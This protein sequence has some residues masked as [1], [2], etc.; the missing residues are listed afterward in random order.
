MVTVSTKNA[1]YNECLANV[2]VKYTMSNMT[3]DTIIT[4]I[5]GRGEIYPRYLTDL[6]VYVVWVGEPD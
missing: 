1:I 3:E 5:N 4:N 6:K 2:H